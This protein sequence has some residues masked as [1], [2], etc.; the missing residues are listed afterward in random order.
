VRYSAPNGITQTTVE[1]V[2]EKP[3]GM[4]VGQTL[5]INVS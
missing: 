2:V 4:R 3:D 5:T 1:F